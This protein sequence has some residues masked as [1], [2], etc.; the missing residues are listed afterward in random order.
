MNKAVR[1]FLAEYSPDVR[2]LATILRDFVLEGA[3][4][5]TEQVDLSS[6]MIGYGYGP[7]YEDMIGA[8]APFKSYVNLNLY[9]GT[10]LPDPAGLL[11]GT[12]KLHRHVKIKSPNDVQDPH[13]RQLFQA[14]VAAAKAR[15]ARANPK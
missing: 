4:D 12:G 2:K 5:A 13:L 10:E 11:E 7:K 1:E 15:R 9:K 8:I 6:K 14:A 3:P